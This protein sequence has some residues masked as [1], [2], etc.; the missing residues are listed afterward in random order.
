[1]VDTKV[2]TIFLLLQ[3]DPGGLGRNTVGLLPEPEAVRFGKV[4]M[5]CGV[6]EE[7]WAAFHTLVALGY[8]KQLAK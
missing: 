6:S 8:D 1:M 2:S 5:A 7:A 3:G 4:A